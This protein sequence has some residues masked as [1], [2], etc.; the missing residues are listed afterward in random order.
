MKPGRVSECVEG[1]RCLVSWGLCNE[2][3]SEE[4]FIITSN[5]SEKLLYPD[6]SLPFT[7]RVKD[8]LGRMTLEEKVGFMNHP[9]HG[10]LRLNIPAYNYWSEA[11]HGVARNWRATVFPQA[12]A[13]AATILRHSLHS[14]LFSFCGSL[15]FPYHLCPLC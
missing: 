10:I 5:T 8:L 4:Y 1:L 12:I 15:D 2:F 13:M 14:E 9:A 3:I 6:T 11:L 7:E